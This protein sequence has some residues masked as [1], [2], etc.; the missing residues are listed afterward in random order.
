[1]STLAEKRDRGAAPP[2][3]SYWAEVAAAARRTASPAWMV[4]FTDLVA[5][6]LTFFVLLFSM[7]TVER[8]KW[9]NLVRSLAG[10]MDSVQ[11]VD[12]AKPAVEFQIDQIRPVPGADLDYLTPLVEQ[13][14]ATEPALATGTLRRESGQV[15]LSLPASALF[16]G[17][18]SQLAGRADAAVYAIGRL[19]QTLDNRVEVHAHAGVGDGDDPEIQGWELS[20]ARASALAAALAEFGHGGRITARGYGAQDPAVDANA[21]ERIEIVIGEDLPEGRP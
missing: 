15:V 18:G 8:Y 7:S 6:M 11:A 3:R 2:G 20:L 9:Q 19:I 1:M 12:G 10:D 17:T 5:L 16:D 4:T 14:L 21:P 13:L